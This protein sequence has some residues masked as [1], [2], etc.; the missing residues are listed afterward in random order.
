MVSK[1]RLA[2]VMLVL[3]ILA[4]GT[5]ALMISLDASAFWAKTLPIAVL[6]G[7]SVFAQSL[8]LFNKATK[9]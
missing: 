7:G 6:V 8:G 9:K 4:G 5:L 2:L 1:P 3:V